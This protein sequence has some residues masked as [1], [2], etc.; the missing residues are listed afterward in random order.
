MRAHRPRGS[1]HAR[2]SKKLETQEKSGVG[3]HDANS[4][5]KAKQG[6][7]RLRQGRRAGEPN[8]SS[9][10]L[11]VWNHPVDPVLMAFIGGT[12]C[13]GDK[14][15]SLHVKRE[16]TSPLFQEKC[17]NL[18]LTRKHFPVRLLWYGSLIMREIPGSLEV[19]SPSELM[20]V[21]RDPTPGCRVHNFL[22]AFAELPGGT[23]TPYISKLQQEPAGNKQAK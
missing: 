14:W 16:R 13:S 9:Y 3:K 12:Y 23:Q 17:S 8:D 1:L 15:T 11:N 5:W 19:T 4:Y 18:L 2:V 6:T 7:S 22:C 20:L 10:I 21:L